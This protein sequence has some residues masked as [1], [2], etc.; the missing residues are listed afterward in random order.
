MVTAS[1]PR[2]QEA[3]SSQAQQHT[4]EREC[5]CVRARARTQPFPGPGM[6]TVTGSPTNGNEPLKKFHLL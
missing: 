4:R 1:Q 3:V 2:L 5:V 6:Y